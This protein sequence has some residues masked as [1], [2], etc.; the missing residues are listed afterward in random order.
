MPRLLRAS[1]PSWPSSAVEVTPLLRYIV[2]PLLVSST[3]LTLAIILGL[4]QGDRT[5][6]GKLATWI[7]S[8]S[9]PALTWIYITR[10]KRSIKYEEV[11]ILVAISWLTVPLSSAI[12]ISYTYNIPLIDAW[13]EA[14]SGYTTTGLTVFNGDISPEAGIYIPS[15]EEAPL[16]LLWWRAVNQW[17]GGFGIVVFFYTLA[18]LGGLPAH[19][20]GLAE[21]RFER[22]EPSIARSIRALMEVYIGITALSFI[23]I[24]AT[25]M[26]APDALYHTL[27]GVAT[28][29]FSTHSDSVGYYTMRAIWFA[30]ML[31]MALGAFNFADTY[32]FFTRTRGRYSG[33]VPFFLLLAVIL[34][35]VLLL[36]TYPYYKS[37]LGD[38]LPHIYNLF[39]AI[40][41]TGFSVAD[42]STMPD[43]YKA[44]IVVAMMIGGSVLSTTGGVKVFR[45]MTMVF[46]IRILVRETIYVA[47]LV[48]PR[49][50]WGQKITE[51]D[52]QRA[53]VI[54]S[55]FTMTLLAGTLAL[56]TILPGVDFIDALF[57]AQSALCTVG[58]SVGITGASLPIQA[59]IVLMTLMTL[60]RLEVV[61]FL[62]ALSATRKLV[63]ETRAKR[64]LPPQEKWIIKKPTIS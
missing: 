36:V 56:L 40:S 24:N 28:G 37:V 8:Y 32:R 45:V 47:G 9:V 60:G 7:V 16:I 5:N 11:F 1:V 35:G 54:I 30:T 6:I 26:P 62:Y 27:T 50:A 51:S 57:E 19:L 34:S 31:A 64:I 63:S 21:G 43:S 38:P 25:G 42:I 33:E 2:L 22:L 55:L 4:L 44:V 49:R 59:K 23:V 3:S 48:V 52:I 13:F 29:G 53:F 14:I 61:G 12:P 17:L 41:G 15:V 10:P 39:S 18:R 46:G 58:L 20:V